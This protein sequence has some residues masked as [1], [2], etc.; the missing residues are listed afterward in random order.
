MMPSI[1]QSKIKTNKNLTILSIE[2]SC[3]DTACALVRSDGTVFAEQIYSQ[4][5]HVEF[6]GVVPEIAAR[7]HL[8]HLSTLV[9]KTITQAQINW[10]EI[11]AIAA[12]CGP[13]LIGGVIVGSSFAKGL[14]L[15]QNLPFIG[16]NH[17]EAHALTVRIPNISSVQVQFPYLL[18]LTS[19]G[20][21][22]CIHVTNIGEYQRLGGTIDDAAGEA[23]DKV[24]KM[25]GLS[26][27]G[28]PALEALAKEGDENAFS[29]PRPLYG[30]PGCDFSFSG[31]KTAVANLLTGYENTDTLPRQLAADIAASFQKAITTAIIN[32]LENAIKM[33]PDTTLLATAGGVAANQYLRKRLLALAE[34]YK[35]PFIAPPMKYCTD[36]AVMIGWAAIEILHQAAN[37]NKLIDDISL[38]PRP[39]WPLSEMSERFKH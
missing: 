2:S 34:Q 13:G 10:S 19:G 26:W 6:G 28:G 27:P 31:L 23:F 17:I 39:R 8:S 21:C 30:R 22:Q 38:L 7:A 20:H 12:T 33:V 36:N 5:E 9:K 25:L 24:A 35:L 29:L 14:A 37:T 18:F 16:I 3:D 1:H 32:R 15:A 4:K 11:D